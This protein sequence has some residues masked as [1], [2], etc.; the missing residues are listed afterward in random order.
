MITRST[1]SILIL[2]SL[3]LVGAVGPLQVTARIVTTTDDAGPGSLREAIELA[4]ASPGTDTITF[5][6]SGTILLASMLPVIAGDLS[7]NGS[8]Q[9]ITID[10]QGGYRLLDVLPG[11]S[12]HLVELS[13][14]NGYSEA[15]GGAIRSAGS[16]EIE[17]CLF[18][19]N[20]SLSG[21]A[22]Y[23]SGSLSVGAGTSFEFNQAETGG[24]IFSSGDLYVAGTIFTGNDASSM[25]GGA[26][27]A[28]GPT[29]QFVD[30]TF[31]DNTAINE[32]AAIFRLG[33]MSISQ[34]EFFQNY[35]YGGTVQI[36]QGDLVLQ[37]SNFMNNIA[38]SNGGAIFLENGSSASIQ[39]VT[40]NGN[41]ASEFGGAVF[42]KNGC[43]LSI[44]GAVINGNHA[45]NGGSIFLENGSSASIQ[46]AVINGNHATNGGAIWNAGILKL[47]TVQLDGNHSHM[48]GG[49]IM[50]QGSLE[51]RG[52][53]ISNHTSEYGGAIQNAGALDI[54]ECTFEANEGFGEGGAISNTGTANL[55]Q[56]TF[57]QNHA[58]D[59][60]AIFNH[61]EMSINHSLFAG[62]HADLEAGGAIFNR[63]ELQI[64]STNFLGNYADQGGGAISGWGPLEINSG[65]F[66]YNSS[67]WGGAIHYMSHSLTTI[68]GATFASN[69]AGHAGGAIM[70]NGHMLV[71]DSTITAN[72]AFDFAGGLYNW[73]AGVL[74]LRKSTLAGNESD[75]SVGGIA[76]SGDLTIENSTLA[77][78]IS[79]E[80]AAA[81][82]NGGTAVV[83]YTT[84]SGNTIQASQGVGAIKNSGS[85][86]IGHSVIAD[87]LGGPNCSGVLT[88]NSLNLSDDE[89]CPGFSIA[90]PLLAPLQDNGGP[91]PTH[92][93]LTGSPAVDI[94]SD[95]DCPST[96]QRGEPRPQGLSCDLGSFEVRQTI[97]SIDIKPKSSLNVIDPEST[98]TVA[99]A[100]LST[101]GF[102]ALGQIDAS[103]LTFGVT[104]WE[105]KPV[106]IQPTGK[107]LCSGWD[108]N[109]DYLQDLV[110]TYGIQG[111][112]FTCES[113][114]GIL[115]G[116]LHDNEWV[117]GTDIIAPRPCPENPPR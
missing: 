50:N 95:P 109:G 48:Y 44:Q 53:T 73:D 52:S 104:G 77:G 61:G 31:T 103:S 8:G 17:D 105:V 88:Q 30:V 84:I 16:L 22:I 86:E 20:V 100:I 101:S 99:I 5:E 87:T 38:F 115:R 6:I 98:G 92:A 24:G 65:L 19:G 21:G 51:M 58:N 28:I 32:G 78:N 72:R 36:Q 110:C 46:G 102:D 9:D 111:T 2:A 57:S 62:N 60:G 40:F 107:L 83:S 80:G 71:E 10:G 18:E 34:A 4:N 89:S 90:D 68:I 55:L 41:A 64:N 1:L 94:A 85:L 116:L 76:N 25:E 79:T 54:A 33:N 14:L 47:E 7:I 15:E 96:D 63:G 11:V 69:Y 37:N 91:T 59:G 81:L 12:L 29:A 43:S 112:N 75:R 114:R 106:I 45:L 93:L 56:V 70:N 39:M 35:S 13:L 97:I 82:G 74:L 42:L 26:V 66:S 23:S 49:G 108:V 3:L 27:Y 67:R 113:D 117:V